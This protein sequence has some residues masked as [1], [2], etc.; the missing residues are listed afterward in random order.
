[1][2]RFLSVIMLSN[3]N[4]VAPVSRDSKIAPTRVGV[5]VLLERDLYRV[6]YSVT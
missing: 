3:K 6:P 4:G 2:W 5:S 1:M